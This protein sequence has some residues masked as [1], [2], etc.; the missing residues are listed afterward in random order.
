MKKALVTI[1]LMLAL[2]LTFT[3]SA[4]ATTEESY[5]YYDGDLIGNSEA[6]SEIQLITGNTVMAKAWTRLLELNVGAHIGKSTT[7][8]NASKNGIFAG[9]TTSHSSTNGGTAVALLNLGTYASSISYSSQ[10][11]HYFLNDGGVKTGYNTID[12]NGITT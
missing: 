3:S 8:I 6:W 2:I 7:T 4:Y 11:T 12:E 5:L 1:S 9:S 10:S